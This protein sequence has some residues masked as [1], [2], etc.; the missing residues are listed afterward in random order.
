MLTELSVKNFKSYREATLPLAGLT[1][2][3][4]AN[5]SGKSNL[6][7]ALQILSWLARGRRLSEILYALKERQLDIRG[8]VTRLAHE[9]EETFEIEVQ[10]GEYPRSWLFFALELQMGA[11]NP[12]VNSWGTQAA[13]PRCLSTRPSRSHAL[14]TAARSRLSTTTS[15]GAV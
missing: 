6:L 2:L 13:Q 9:G 11:Q 5:A 8:P 14:L 4:G 10:V 3:I 1:V 15:P 12:R 7:E